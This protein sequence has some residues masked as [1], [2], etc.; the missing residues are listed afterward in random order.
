MI[1][2]IVFSERQQEEYKEKIALAKQ[3]ADSDPNQSLSLLMPMCEDDP[4]DPLVLFIIGYIY[5]QAEKLPLAYQIHKRLL[6][7]APHR[8]EVWTNI[9]RICDQMDRY[10]EAKEYFEQALSMEQSAGAYA[11][12]AVVSLN[13]GDMESCVEYSKKGLE[14]DPD[15]VNCWMNLGFG[16]LGLHD[17]K[18][19][20][21]GYE[22]GLGGRFRKEW[23]Y[24]DEQRWDGTPG[25]NVVFYGEQGIGDEILFASVIPDAIK[26][27]NEVII[28]CDKRL[29]GLF[30]RSFPDAFVYGTRRDKEAS[31]PRQ[32]NIDAR[33]ALGGLPEFYR[34]SD[35]DFPGIPYLQ[36]DPE[37]EI[38]WSA[39]FRSWGERPKIGIAWSGGQIHTQSR[40]RRLE[41]EQLKPIIDSFDADFI[42][43]QYK[44]PGDLSKYGIRH[45]QA[46][47]SDNYDNVAGLVSQLD[48]VIAVPTAV[49]HLAGGLGIPTICLVPKYINWRFQRDPWVWNKSVNLIRM[50]GDY[51]QTLMEAMRDRL[52]G[53]YRGGQETASSIHSGT[54]IN[55]PA[56]KQAY[57]HNAAD[58]PA[59]THKTPR[60]N[61]LHF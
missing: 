34:K 27:C 28:D 47:E 32:H 51:I 61:R 10:D 13:M 22:Y 54:V 4:N 35:Q 29:E 24:G 5:L 16:S 30:K 49:V 41:L 38:M 48:L 2:N 40:F 19:G 12:M 15:H 57:L 37:R 6:E 50:E 9:G 20:W 26:D 21:K 17:W 39:L 11:N 25:K 52:P 7:L 43:L 14:I 3:L 58:T 33:C 44:D 8:F 56:L 36:A 46:T 59:V 60:I 23:V 55:Y 53:F 1:Q 45:F 42:S 18:T 31:W